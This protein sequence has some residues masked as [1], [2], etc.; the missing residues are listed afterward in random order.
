M[1]TR[2]VK[3]GN[4]API[5]GKKDGCVDDLK[6][7][8]VIF[9]P[10]P[11]DETLGCGGTIVRK[12]AEGARVDVAF[13]TD[14]SGSHNLL[15]TGE[16]ARIRREE[17]LKACGVLGL[18]EKRVHFFDLQ[19]GLLAEQ[20]EKALALTIEFL[21]G[22]EV[23]EAFVTYRHEPLPD[24]AAANQIVRRAIDEMGRPMSVWEY[25]IW[26]WDRW[27]WV[28]MEK[29]Y[30]RHPWGMTKAI[31]HGLPGMILPTRFNCVIDISKQLDLKRS[32]LAQHRTQVTR[33]NGDPDWKTLG[34][35]AEG[36]FLDMLLQPQEVFFKYEVQ[37]SKAI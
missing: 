5:R 20:V 30:W 16:L 37:A 33:Y 10:H 25:P 24:H 15:P 23:Q 31:A 2:K 1:I 35:L 26:Y 36:R 6:S 34:D 27:P 9:A 11:D 12:L 8:A 17:A 13:F 4:S 29:G 19:D 7:P 32:A 22:I 3:A 14:G 28:R 18:E 21:K